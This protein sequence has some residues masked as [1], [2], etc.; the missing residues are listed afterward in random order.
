MILAIAEYFKNKKIN[1][2]AENNP[3]LKLMK[4]K[5]FNEYTEKFKNTKPKSR[6]IHEG[7]SIQSEE[8]NKF[9]I[10]S[11]IKESGIPVI[12]INEL[13]YWEYNNRIMVLNKNN[14]EVTYDITSY[15]PG[16]KSFGEGYDEYANE[17]FEESRGR[18]R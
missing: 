13:E 5:E 1:K 2:D 15:I 10:E 16:G 3:Y 9:I 17:Y 18:G 4:E 8:L 11:Y 7:E 12:N 6:V 14:L